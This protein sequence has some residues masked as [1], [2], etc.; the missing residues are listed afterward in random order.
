VPLE[1]DKGGGCGR[2]PISNTDVR[3][4]RTHGRCRRMLA[5]GSWASLDGSAAH[6]WQ[7]RD[8][9]K[10]PACAGLLITEEVLRQVATYLVFL[11]AALTV[12][13]TLLV[14]AAVALAM[15]VSNMS[16]D[17]LT[18]LVALS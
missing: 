5:P 12:A 15:L 13:A 6:A 3:T 18:I 8:T 10:S 16:I 4:K 11:A 7:M 9:K 2:A 17:C 1:A 14:A